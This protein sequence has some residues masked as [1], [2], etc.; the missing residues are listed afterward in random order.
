L[1]NGKN[2]ADSSNFHSFI[3]CAMQ[4]PANVTGACLRFSERNLAL[5]PCPTDTLTAWIPRKLFHAF[6]R[7]AV[8]NTVIPESVAM[9]ISGHKDRCVFERYNI[10]DKKDLKE[11]AERMKDFFESKKSHIDAEPDAKLTHSDPTKEE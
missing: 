8:R 7:T 3:G 11:A 9:M 10:V 6:R 2:R 1:L 4:I 5:S